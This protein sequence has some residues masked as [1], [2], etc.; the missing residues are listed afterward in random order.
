MSISQCNIMDRLLT[1]AEDSILNQK[2]AAAIC[3]GKKIYCM[4]INN[5]R[6]KFGRKIR[7]CGH[8]EI[9]CI[10]RLN[11]ILKSIFKGS[12]NINRRNRKMNKLTIYIARRRPGG[13]RAG[14]S[15]P[16]S[17]CHDIISQLGIKKMVYYNRL[18][19]IISCK[20][21]NYK[22][23]GS[24]HGSDWYKSRNIPCLY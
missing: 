2:H 24:S 6:T 1:K 16:C 23:Y 8:S 20:T 14:P 18:G 19:E 11:S 9:V 13:S 10:E 21:K 3:A 4:N 5:N 15:G 12:K 22:T 17:H 7:C